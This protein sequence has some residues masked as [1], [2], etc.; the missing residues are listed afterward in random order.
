MGLTAATSTALQPLLPAVHRVGTTQLP[1][2]LPHHQ[3]PLLNAPSCAMWRDQRSCTSHPTACIA[4]ELPFTPWR[5]P[6]AIVAGQMLGRG[7]H[8]RGCLQ[9]HKQAPWNCKM[10]HTRKAVPE[11]GCGCRSHVDLLTEEVPCARCWCLTMEKV[12]PL[13]LVLLSLGLLIKVKI[14]HLLKH[15]RTRAR[16]HTHTNYENIILSMV[17]LI[18]SIR[19]Y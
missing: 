19:M 11:W 8:C 9:V 3:H 12:S 1:L 6:L 5:W 2:L 18:F 16:A 7:T 17:K 15:T 13:T 14:T 10:K 4:E